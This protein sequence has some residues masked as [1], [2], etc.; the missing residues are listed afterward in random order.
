V[1]G[2]LGFF[3]DLRRRRVYRTAAIYAVISWG[4]TEALTTVFTTLLF[5]AWAGM[6]VVIAFLVGFPV[7]MYLAWVF[8]ITPEGIRRTQPTSMQG[9]VALTLSAVMLFGG[10]ATLF[11][12]IYPGERMADSALVAI[13]QAVDLPEDTIAVLPF[14]NATGDEGSAYYADGIAETLLSQLSQ[15]SSL[16][17]IA[18]DSSFSLRN[19][20]MDL[21]TKARRLNAGFLLDG[22]VQRAG[23]VIRIIARL[24]DGETGEYLWA[25]TY[26]GGIAD[27]F[28]IQD[29][30][31]A[32][33]VGHLNPD[34]ATNAMAVSAQRRTENVEAFDA[35]LR[36]LYQLNIATPEALE[37]AVA[38]FSAAIELDP[39]FALAYVGRANAHSIDS[40][41]GIRGSYEG[42]APIRTDATDYSLPFDT[43]RQAE[44]LTELISD[45]VR[46]ALELAP[47]LAETHTASGLL[48]LIQQDYVRAEASLLHAIELN[49][50]YAFAYHVYGLFLREVNRFDESVAALREALAL[51]ALSYTLRLDIAMGLYYVSDIDGSI[52][53]LR[54]LMESEP[55]RLAA[56]REVLVLYGFAGRRAEQ[57]RHII[58]YQD[59]L[60]A[61]SMTTW[62]EAVPIEEWFLEATTPLE[63]KSPESQ[64]VML[65]W[66]RSL[67][68]DDPRLAGWVA[69]NAVL[70][71]DPRWAYDRAAEIISLQEPVSVSMTSYTD[72]ANLANRYG[73]YERVIEYMEIV[74]SS[75]NPL[76]WPHEFQRLENQSP[77]L[78]ALE[79]AMAH[80]ELGDQAEAERLIHGALAW[81]DEIEANG[82]RR[83]VLDAARAK[84]YALLGETDRA[85][86]L[87]DRFADSQGANLFYLD[88]SEFMD[89][90]DDPRFL[91]V[92]EKIEANQGAELE[93][94]NAIIAEYW[95]E[96]LPAESS[97]EEAGD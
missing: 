33:V 75:S 78:C 46:R 68:D 30:I 23:D 89:I 85:F 59:E 77:R 83:P 66:M 24:V 36:G 71:A 80:R 54:S 76:D 64:R 91:A 37:R 49:P 15:V 18:R 20:G 48:L 14:W 86:E 4:L 45:D 82:F 16:R 42:T 57:A 74:R 11:W 43:R 73:D 8:D 40:G 38:E 69:D 90:E 55:D 47:G 70:I 22:S 65:E 31:S 97:A 67:P 96:H 10:T 19:P 17:V 81:M 1:S 27:V 21:R 50:S 94:V 26:D 88:D 53:Q 3:Q 41:W 7:A 52:A 60:N 34:R 63:P 9:W 95:E 32:A 79:L 6:L 61:I 56:F 25:E 72:T 5:P 35:Y 51:D 58:A 13:E 28:D 39:E 84:A 2:L 62:G 93:R 87:L 12:L 92:I 44:E 29:R